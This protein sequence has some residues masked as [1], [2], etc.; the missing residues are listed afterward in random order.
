MWLCDQIFNHRVRR[1]DHGTLQEG[2]SAKR[3]YGSH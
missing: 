1:T 3:P 2:S